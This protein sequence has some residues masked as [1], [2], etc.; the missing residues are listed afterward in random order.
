MRITSALTCGIPTT[1]SEK[2]IWEKRQEIINN[3]KLQ[4]QKNIRLAKLSVM[5]YVY[6]EDP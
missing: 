3:K 1:Q 5:Q 2:K 4:E 6:V